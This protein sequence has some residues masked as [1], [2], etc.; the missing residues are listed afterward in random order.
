VSRRHAR[1]E[2]RDENWAVVD[3]GS[4]NG[5]FVNG[6]RVDDYVLEDGD[7][8]VIGDT[9]FKFLTG[10]NIELSYHKELYRMTIVDVQT[11]AFNKR[12]LQEQLER[13][14]ARCSRTH[15]PLSLVLFD[16]DHFKDV[17]DTYGHLA[18]DHVLRDLAS[19]MLFRI[20]K[21]DLLA[22]YGGEEFAL[23]LPETTNADAALFAEQLRL[24]VEQRPFVYE[25]HEIRATISGGVATSTDEI[26]RDEFI[27]RADSN[28]FRAKRGGR[29]QVVG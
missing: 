4:K 24:L 15:R 23:M 22:R 10:A 6:T 9:I 28:L 5:T 19:R 1:I 17:N 16:I 3:L 11:H 12:Y 29:N 25:G 7:L 21:T 13:E 14:L 2:R 20:R 26:P 8:I 18:G 27:G